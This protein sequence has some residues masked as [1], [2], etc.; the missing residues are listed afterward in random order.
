MLVEKTPKK[1]KNRQ[2]AENQQKI[3]IRSKIRDFDFFRFFFFF[4]SEIEGIC[5]QN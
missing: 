4:F 1:F 5:G 2:N 3:Y